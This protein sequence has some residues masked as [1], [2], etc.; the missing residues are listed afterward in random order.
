VERAVEQRRVRVQLCLLVGGEQDVVPPHRADPPLQ[1]S[2]LL[3]V[4]RLDFLAVELAVPDAVT[5]TDQR[6]E[7]L[8]GDV[9]AEDQHLDLVDASSVDPL[10]ET[11]LGAV[12]IVC[13]KEP[14]VDR[15][16]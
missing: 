13:Q 15:I 12:D 16:A 14:R 3:L 4:A 1:R 6:D 11:L 9:A 7:H 8:P 5:A 10:A 2:E